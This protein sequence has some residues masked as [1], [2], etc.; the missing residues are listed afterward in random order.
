MDKQKEESEAMKINDRAL[1][2]WTWIWFYGPDF[3]RKEGWRTVDIGFIN[4]HKK[5]ANGRLMEHG[6]HYRGVWFRM[7]FWLPFVIRQWR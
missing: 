6:K 1:N 7:S 3:Y 5:P 4:I 2:Q